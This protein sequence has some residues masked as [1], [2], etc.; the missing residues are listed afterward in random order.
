VPLIV[1]TARA[2]AMPIADALH[3]SIPANEAIGDSFGHR[4]IGWAFCPTRQLRDQYRSRVA[5]GKDDDRFWLKCVEFYVLRMRYSYRNHRPAWETLLGWQR[6]VLIGE[7]PDP[8]R[9]F[10]SVLAR[11]VISR[12]GA[13]YA[14]EILTTRVSASVE[15]PTGEP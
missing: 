8:A 13:V 11:E 4:G 14:G 6:V 12:L 10:S 7:E 5:A 1:H 9:C 15:A 3:V 2:T